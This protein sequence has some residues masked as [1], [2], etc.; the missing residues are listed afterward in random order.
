M[1]CIVK[2]WG[3]LKDC[4]VCQRNKSAMGFIEGLLRSEGHDT[5]LVVVD[6]FGKYAQFFAIKHRFTAKT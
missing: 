2:A 3:L 6:H 1:S 5:I 4:V